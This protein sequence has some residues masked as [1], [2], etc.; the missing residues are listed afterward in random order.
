MALVSKIYGMIFFQTMK[1]LVAS[2]MV[3]RQKRHAKP[4]LLTAMKKKELCKA[5]QV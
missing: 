3:K 4:I 1:P 2:T 5:N